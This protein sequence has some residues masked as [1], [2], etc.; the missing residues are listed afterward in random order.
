MGQQF[1]KQLQKKSSD[2]QRE[3]GRKSA[4]SQLKK[5]KKRK[6]M[7]MIYR[8]PVYLRRNPSHHEPRRLTV[9][10]NGSQNFPLQGDTVFFSGGMDCVD[11]HRGTKG[12]PVPIPLP[13]PVT[14]SSTTWGLLHVSDTS[15]ALTVSTEMTFSTL[16]GSRFLPDTQKG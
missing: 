10:G 3:R 15:Q 2:L 5:K 11:L 12:Q 13:Q 1:N 6:K 7:Q 8:L 4:V 9:K 14:L 16:R